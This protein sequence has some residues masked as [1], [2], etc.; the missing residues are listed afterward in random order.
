MPK[1]RTTL[2]D[3]AHQASVSTAV[4]SYVINNG[5]RPTSSEVRARVLQAITDLDYHPNSIARG[6]RARRS[7]MIGFIANDFHALDS[8]GSHYLASILSAFTAELK[9]HRHYMVM[10][11]LIVGEDPA[12]LDDLIRSGHLDGVALRRVEDPPT[13]DPLLTMIKRAEMPCVC[14]ERPAGPAFGITSILYD[15]HGGGAM[16]T[17]HL[18]GKGHRRIAH[19]GGDP[20][21]ASAQAREAGYRAALHEAGITPELELMRV[22]N[23]NQSEAAAV[24]RELMGLP[25]PPT[26]IFAA[27]DDMALGA[28]EA[29]RAMSHRIPEDVAVIGF[30]GIALG[31]S[32]VL[33]LSSI[34]V[35]LAEIG[36]RAARALIGGPDAAVPDPATD[37]LPVELI[38]GQTT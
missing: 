27:S 22:A 8:F 37:V 23:W 16:A 1:K 30:D 26:A 13:P 11:P 4:V 33:P 32:A 31:Q 19:L 3:V 20:R 36:R 24:T 12:P 34:R 2:R 17:M 18:L 14:I 15:D 9:Q 38:I 6:L 25:H 35:P 21:Y 10:Y 5:P 7:H 29:L 28:L